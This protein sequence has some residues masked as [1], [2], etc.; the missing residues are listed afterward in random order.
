MKRLCDFFGRH[1]R[2]ATAMHVILSAGPLALLLMCIVGIAVISIAGLDF[3]QAVPCMFIL[4][5][6]VCAVLSCSGLFL[7]LALLLY[8]FTENARSK[9]PDGLRMALIRLNIIN[10]FMAFGT[11]LFWIWYCLS[12]K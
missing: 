4:I 2:F 6:V 7:L 5:V 1:P 12:G 3:Y 10:G 11:L 9:W 8:R